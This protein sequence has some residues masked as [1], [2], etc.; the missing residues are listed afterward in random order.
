MAKRVIRRKYTVVTTVQT[1][2]E[3]IEMDSNKEDSHQEEHRFVPSLTLTRKKDDKDDLDCVLCSFRATTEPELEEHIDDKHQ[4]IFADETKSSETTN[5]GNMIDLDCV[6]CS[7]TA[8]SKD[9]LEKHINDKHDDIFYVSDEMPKES[10]EKKMCN[11]T[12]STSLSVE[13]EATPASTSPMTLESTIPTTSLKTSLS[14]NSASIEPEKPKSASTSLK[15]RHNSELNCVLCNATAIDEPA[16]ESHISKKHQEIFTI[17]IDPAQETIAMDPAQ[18]TIVMDPAQETIVM[19]PAQETKDTD[20]AEERNGASPNAEPSA[21]TALDTGYSTSLKRRHN[22]DDS[23][24]DLS[25][26]TDPE[27]DMS[28]P[29]LSDSESEE[30]LKKNANL[31]QKRCRTDFKKRESKKSTQHKEPLS[32]DDDIIEVDRVERVLPMPLYEEILKKNA[33]LLQKRCRTDFKKTESKKS[34]QHKEPLSDD[35]DIIEVGRVERVLLHMK[36]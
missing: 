10:Q 29:N 25:D 34:T 15:R 22:T 36:K 30:I 35:D 19:D 28:L 3:V 26:P 5:A 14:L 31:L 12:M 7:F 32:D 18:E 13:K 2:E 17:D 9:E 8:T 1:L 21:S 27:P 23:E 6:L 4:E 24:S 11:Q 33:I 20:A 16:L